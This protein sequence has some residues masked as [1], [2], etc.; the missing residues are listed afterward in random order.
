MA[1]LKEWFILGVVLLV[2]SIISIFITVGSGSFFRPNSVAII[3]LSGIISYDHSPISLFGETIT[4]QEVDE[5]VQYVKEDPSIKA[6]VIFINS[7]GGSAAASE[8]I[9][10]TLRDLANDV[11]VVSYIGEYGASGGYY[12]ALA[13]DQ[14][15]ASPHSLTG[16]IGAI[17]LII[18]YAE[19]MSKIGIKAETFK[20]G[21][22]KDIGSPWRE[23]NDEE[24][25]VMQSMI[26]SI[27][28]LFEQRVRERRADKVKDWE[29]VLSARP[30]TGVQALKAGL[31]DQIGTLEDAIRI[32]REL[33]GLPED[34]PSEW[35]RPQL[36]LLDLI[37]G[38]STK[39]NLKLSYEVLLMWPLPSPAEPHKMLISRP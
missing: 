15:I 12:I 1:K 34:A 38:G 18:N 39:G 6:V 33:A 29:E 11:V 14:I 10:Q 13:G 31:I 35:I 22:M 36:G 3:E 17:S 23:I 26:D 28:E 8:E 30:F 32:A 2:C 20:S 7:P 16:S 19:L 21:S 24:R 37:F 5:M 9:Y 4:P 25:K 27:A